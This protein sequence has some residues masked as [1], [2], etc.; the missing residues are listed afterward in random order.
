MLALT[1]K[2]EWLDAVRQGQAAWI[3]AIATLL[4]LLASIA[5]WQNHQNYSVT[6]T[7]VAKSERT[8][9]LEQGEKGPHSAA[10]YGVYVLKPELSLAMLDPGL[11]D[12]QGNVLRLEAHKRNDT[13]FRAIQD[14]IPMQRFGTLYPSFVLQALLPLLIILVGYPLIAAEREQGT[15]KQLLA[16]GCSPTGLFFAKAALLMSVACVVLIPF[17]I[18]LLYSGLSQPNTHWLRVSL[19][20]LSYVSYLFIWCVLTIAISSIMPTARR[21]LIALLALWAISSLLLPKVAISIAT[22]KHP[23]ESGQ[24]FQAK[25][26]SQVYTPERLQ[27]IAQFKQDTL[28]KYAVANTADLPF[29]WSGEQLQFGERY[30]DK[31]FDTLFDAR[32]AK[33]SQQ[34]Q[35]YQ[36]VAL[37]SPYIALQS[38]SMG[39]AGTDHMH[40]QHFT[41][42]AE[43]HRRMMQQVLNFD[44]RDHGHKSSGRYVA[45]QTLWSAIPTFNYQIPHLQH[46]INHYYVALF[47]LLVWLVLICLFSVYGIRRLSKGMQK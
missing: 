38:L 47:C 18:F 17:A 45:D 15:L 36:W 2:K 4:L 40:H 37:L 27:A 46:M 8:R 12:H 3:C 25:L 14:T 26:E 16:A 7:A 20:A 35:S 22:S 41:S 10:H 9:W 44:Q 30:A 28:L 43:Q 24:S 5:S 23:I 13:V 6:K 11:R 19:F 32:T 33:L 34:A 39:L 29:D 42:A 21:A 31:I 1:A